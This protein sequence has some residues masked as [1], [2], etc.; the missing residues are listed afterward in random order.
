MKNI[1]SILKIDYLDS[2][3]IVRTDVWDINRKIALAFTNKSIDP[4]VNWKATD[5]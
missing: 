2:K 4:S 3:C 5:K 1:T